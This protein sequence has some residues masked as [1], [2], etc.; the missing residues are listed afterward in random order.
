[1]RSWAHYNVLAVFDL[2]FHA[3]VF[4]IDHLTHEALGD[5]LETSSNF[6]AKAWGRA[7]REK[8][9][10]AITCVGTLHI[11]TKHASVRE[12]K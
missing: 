1:L 8:A 11:Q 6:D 7:A 5:L 12:P 4:E 2:D 10:E 9:A 3:Q